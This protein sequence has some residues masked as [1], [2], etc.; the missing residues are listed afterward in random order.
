M[1]EGK[2][3]KYRILTT[4]KT[5]SDDG[6]NKNENKIIINKKVIRIFIDKDKMSS[7]KRKKKQ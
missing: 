4:K 3:Q 2:Q 5:I 7:K 1:G 6:K